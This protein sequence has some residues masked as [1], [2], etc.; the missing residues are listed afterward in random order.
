MQ[1]RWRFAL[2]GLVAATFLLGTACSSDDSGD[3]ETEA[4]TEASATE[5]MTETAT[6]TEAMT[7]TATA[8]EA[9]TEAAFGLAD[10]NGLACTGQW[11]NQT[12][13]S[14]GSFAATFSAGEGGGSVKLELGGN[15]FGGQGGTVEAPFTTEGETTVINADLG[16]LGQAMLNFNGTSAGEAV[17]ENPPALGEG[18]KATVTD[19][20]FDGKSL[21]AGLDIEFANNG[22]TAHSILESTC[23]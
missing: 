1:K 6:A 10:L 16:F 13:G 9:A 22:G 2:T 12:F 11:T 17:L 4:T 7:E 15:V 23:E 18:S 8:T 14:T 3:E 19:F 20:A 5:A 21:T